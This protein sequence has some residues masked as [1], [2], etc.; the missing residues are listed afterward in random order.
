MIQ[1]TPLVSTQLAEF[2][3]ITSLY[4]WAMMTLG[5]FFGGALLQ[6]VVRATEP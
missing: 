6:S 4:F 1:L 5:G 2:E 3:K